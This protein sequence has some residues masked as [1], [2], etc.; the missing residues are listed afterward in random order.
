MPT[1]PVE[2]IDH[3]WSPLVFVIEPELV[4]NWFGKSGLEEFLVP[5]VKF[6]AD[7]KH[8]AVWRNAED[9]TF[10]FSGSEGQAFDTTNSAPVFIVLNV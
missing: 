7:G 9:V 1:M 4:R 5:L 2:S 10:V 3:I 6:G 8:F